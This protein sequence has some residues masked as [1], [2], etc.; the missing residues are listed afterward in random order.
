MSSTEEKFCLHWNDFASNLTTAFKDIRHDQDFLDVTLAC[1]SNKQIQAHKVILGACSPFFRSILKNNPHQHPLLYLKGV[2]YEE[3]L[4]VL[5]FIYHGEVNVAQEDLAS[6][7][8]VAK[9]LEVKG[10]TQTVQEENKEVQ[11]PVMKARTEEHL[12]NKSGIKPSH[13]LLNQSK[14]SQVSEPAAA[15]MDL[16]HSR[17]IVDDNDYEV[18]A[19]EYGY[20]EE[21]IDEQCRSEDQQGQDLDLAQGIVNYAYNYLKLKLLVSDFGIRQNYSWKKGHSEKKNIPCEIC[22]KTFSS[23]DSLRNHLG[24][25]KGRTTCT[26]C[27]KVFATISSLNLHIKNSHL[28]DQ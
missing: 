21:Y 4:S 18:V 2:K 13:S 12:H 26:I 9:E 8:S 11:T 14:C 6:F 27:Q 24:I 28:K 19:S 16:D 3:M 20:N 5:D 22:F 7:L 23:K 17:E 25:H 15:L 1:G 10:L